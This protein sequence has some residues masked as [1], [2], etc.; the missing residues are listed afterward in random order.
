MSR[1]SIL[2]L[3]LIA[4]VV[5]CFGIPTYFLLWGL[6][7]FP[8]WTDAAA[9]RSGLHSWMIFAIT[10]GCLGLGGLFLLLMSLL[11][12]ESQEMSKQWIVVT[13]L[14]LSV[15]L[16]ALVAFL[17]TGF[18]DLRIGF[19]VAALLFFWAP[20]GCCLHL[21]ALAIR[22]SRNVRSVLDR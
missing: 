17:T 22:R 13:S 20:L 7:T 15:G 21:V 18:R 6:V 8:L 3:L 11:S 10:V 14:L 1:H 4:E 19:D 16:A 5:L 2:A 12:S 9:A